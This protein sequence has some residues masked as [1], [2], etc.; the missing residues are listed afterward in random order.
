MSSHLE[1][2]GDKLLPTVG[3]LNLYTHYLPSRDMANYQGSKFG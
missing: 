3:S 2:D 1:T